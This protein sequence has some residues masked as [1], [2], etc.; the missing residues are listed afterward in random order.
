MQIPKR[1]WTF[2]AGLLMGSS[3]FA[4]APPPI[5]V[6][7]T[8]AAGIAG[9]T[10]MP[11]FSLDVNGYT[12]DSIELA[13][14]YTDPVLSFDLGNSTAS[15]NGT[16]VSW[17]ALMPSFFP[18]G[19]TTAGDVSTFEFFAFQVNAP[20]ITGPLVLRPA[21]TVRTGAPLGGTVIGISGTIAT[22]PVFEERSFSTDA[23]IT[24]SAVPEPEMW[25]L[26]LAGAGLI[27]WKRRARLQH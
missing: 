16:T 2:A 18:L 20:T 12:F 15:Y 14:T 5:P 22:D 10:V 23:T 19:P 3:A 11:S 6:T 21:F 27:A 4:L 26:W 13:L 7:V 25:L 8:P 9:A 1:L 17:A 24:V